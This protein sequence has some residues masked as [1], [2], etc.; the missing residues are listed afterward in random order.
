M[1]SFLRKH[2]SLLLTGL[3]LVLAWRGHWFQELLPID[4]PQEIA[5]LL[6]LGTA[7]LWI[8]ERIPL[9][10]TSLLVL[11]L[12]LTWLLP[13]IEAAGKDVSEDLFYLAFFGDITLLF[14]G[15]FVLSAVLN[16]YGLANR[17]A[18]W[19][20]RRTGDQPRYVLL[21]IIL[22]S[23]V[24]SMWMSNTATAAMMF[25]IMA[26]VI[27]GIP[28]TSA[29]AKAISIGIPFACNLGGLGTPI[30]TP[31]N[32]IALDYLNKSGFQ[33]GFAEWMLLSVPLMLILLF[34]LWILLQRLFPAGDITLQMEEKDHSPYTRRQYYVIGIFAFAVVGWLTSGA[35]GLSA[36]TIGLFVVIIT[37]GSGLLATRD[38]RAISWDILF[39]LGGGLCLGVGLKASGLTATLAQMLP[40]E[41]GFLVLLLVLLFLAAI[42]TTFMSNTATANLLI[43]IAVSLP[44]NPFLFAVAIAIMC[45]SSMAM[46][47]ST[48]PNAIAFG[49]GL[50][51]AR[52]MVRTGLI[53]TLLALAGTLLAGLYY[54]PILSLGQS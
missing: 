14:L 31:P 37:F 7:Y 10:I 47:V 49:S 51:K 50:I 18:D 34:L 53:V 22:I 32:A 45:S 24:L 35:T 36:G 9:Y 4:Q 43:P 21:G 11:L 46:P 28:N 25:A 1:L 27:Q 19:M 15:G 52:D 5:I 13:T 17:L 29:F 33:L 23:S 40:L 3:L 44:Q 20:L 2:G 26:P 6:L 12:S 8:T 30:G 54:F 48:P 16:K 41:Q 38:F 39:M 42:M